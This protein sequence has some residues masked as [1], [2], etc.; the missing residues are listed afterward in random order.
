MK[1]LLGHFLRTTQDPLGRAQRPRALA[2]QPLELRQPHGRVE[3]PAGQRRV[4]LGLVQFPFGLTQTVT[5]RSGLATGW[6]GDDVG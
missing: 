3:S 6:R 4:Q 2:V 1:P 5:F